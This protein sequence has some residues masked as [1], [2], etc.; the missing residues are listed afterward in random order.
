M[1]FA[2]WAHRWQ[3]PPHAVQELLA[4]FIAEP[5]EK[6][7]GDTEGYSQSV[8]RLDAARHGVH[9]WRNNV[10]AGTLEDGSFLRWGLA[11]DSQKVNERLKSADLVGWRP[12]IVLPE[13]V[14]K[15]LGQFVSRECKRPG[16]K[17]RGTPE[18]EAQMRWAML[19]SAAGGDAQIVTGAGSFG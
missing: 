12:V 3:I 10:G 9:L 4:C 18:E 11:N 1:T 6:P 2:E 17:W 5:T 15:L 7:V 16:W 8:V 19:V 13:H 14:G